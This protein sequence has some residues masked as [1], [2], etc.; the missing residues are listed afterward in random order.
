VYT[1]PITGTT[2]DRKSLS[3]TDVYTIV[4]TELE[5]RR[6]CGGWKKIFPK[7]SSGGYLHFS[8]VNNRNR[9]LIEYLKLERKVADVF[10][11]PNYYPPQH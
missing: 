4:D 5:A 9:L 8:Q 6:V 2:L 10:E 1:S 3:Q 7:A 11:F